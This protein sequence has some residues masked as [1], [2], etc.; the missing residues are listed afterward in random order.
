MFSHPKTLNLLYTLGDLSGIGPE[1]FFKFT[2]DLERISEQEWQF[3]KNVKIILADDLSKVK[4]NTALLKMGEASSISGEHSYQTLV[5]AH[6]L[7]RSGLAD[8]LITGPVSKESLSLAKHHYSGQT[9]LLAKLNKLT[10]SDVE[11]LFIAQDGRVAERTSSRL[12]RRNDRSALG[13]HEDHEDDENAEMGVP[14]HAQD[15]RIILATR[16]IPLNEVSKELQQNFHKVIKHSIEL[17]DIVFNI[18]SPSIGIAGL[19]PHAGEN[20]LIGDE[21][22][23]WMNEVIKSFRSLHPEINL[24]D[25]LPADSILAQAARAFLK[26]ES[27]AHDLY[28]SAYHDQCLPLI[29]GIAGY[30]AIN[31][32]YGLPYIRVSVDHGCAFDIAGKGIADH[33]ALLACT[34]F[35][36]QQSLKNNLDI[37]QK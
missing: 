33:S 11:M 27:V 5:K 28:I 4:K 20:G 22:S 9:E 17:L 2:R 12:R 29:K 32:T 35:C 8:Y 36:I 30:N 21:E 16:H 37:Y 3:N 26:G 10:A 18:K 14:L 1:I 24:T 25:T 31:M 13:V 6:S 23:T 19:N 7:C 15:F 34:N